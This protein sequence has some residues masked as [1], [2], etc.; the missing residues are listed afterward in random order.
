MPSP[1]DVAVTV[2]IVK[3]GL[4]LM[5]RARLAVLIPSLTCTVKLKVPLAVGLLPLSVLPVSVIPPG[6][7]P[8][9][10]VQL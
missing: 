9:V 5:L 6:K 8:L 7:A 4:I 2:E 1:E 10:I 3:A